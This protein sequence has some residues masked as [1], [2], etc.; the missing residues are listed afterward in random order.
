ML[1]ENKNIKN[2][3]AAETAS[4]AGNEKGLLVVKLGDP[5]MLSLIHI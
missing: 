5:Y 2:E 1:D 3:E 4:F